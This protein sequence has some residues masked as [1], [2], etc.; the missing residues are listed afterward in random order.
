VTG[1]LQ[2]HLV[3]VHLSGGLGDDLASAPAANQPSRP[4][5]RRPLPSRDSSGE[6]GGSPGRCFRSFA[7]ARPTSPPPTVSTPPLARILQA[8]G[9]ARARIPCAD[10]ARCRSVSDSGEMLVHEE[11]RSGASRRGDFR[12]SPIA[13]TSAKTPTTSASAWPF[14]AV[15]KNMSMAPCSATEQR[16]VS[17]LPVRRKAALSA[18]LFRAPA[19][20]E[21]RNPGLPGGQLLLRE[22]AQSGQDFR[23]GQSNRNLRAVSSG[24]GWSSR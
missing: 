23:H 19:A 10:S 15:H 11:C 1:G 4:Q 17:S 8:H 21:G 12:D 14:A 20:A 6:P 2:A 3:V 13:A 16:W 7:R 5:R 24:R 22:I 18:E 9:L